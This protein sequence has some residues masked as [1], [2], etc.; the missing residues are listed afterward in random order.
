MN[1]SPSSPPRPGAPQGPKPDPARPLEQDLGSQ[2][3][4]EAL[5]S[6]FRVIHWLMIL[7]LIS[8]LF[9][10]IVTIQ[11][12]EV[13]VIL[14]FGKA[15]ET[16]G[17]RLLQPG[18]HF[19]FPY[20]IDEIVRIPVGLSQTVQSTIGWYA[21]TPELEA[22]NQEPP[23]RDALTPGADGYLI[24][25]DGNILHCRAT[26]KYRI[27]DPVRHAFRFREMKSI[28]QNALNNALLHGASEFT[29]DAALYRR[30]IEFKEA[31]IEHLSE[32][33][34]S[35]ELGI[36]LDPLDIQVAAPLSVRPAFEAVLAAEQER[37]Q[38]I[39]EA[40]ADAGQTILKSAGESNAVHS[41]SLAAS[42][43]MV[44]AVAAEAQF[45]SAQRQHFEANPKLVSQRLITE[46]LERVFTNAQDKFILPAGHPGVA[47]E[48]RLQLNR[49]P[50]RLTTKEP[51][52]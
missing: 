16:R 6:G 28:L 41:A 43:Q 50:V 46:T 22:K 5:K 14:R 38:R 2:A 39:N 20:P 11:P 32:R 18:L 27:T 9:S 10:G 23:A 30:K 1:Q 36:T 51:Q 3:L 45:F 17:D 25:S 42:N 19:A 34:R 8:A 47:R 15:V 35:Q 31:V 29:A 21:T 12:N 52:L 40:Q 44:L 7:V 13:A 33:I 24:T 48:L 26:L 49:E 37:S 4:N